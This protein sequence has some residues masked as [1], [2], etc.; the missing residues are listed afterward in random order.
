MP[1][2]SQKEFYKFHIVPCQDRIFYAESS[3]NWFYY[4]QLYE[5]AK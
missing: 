2:N 5:L 1:V 4:S 3:N